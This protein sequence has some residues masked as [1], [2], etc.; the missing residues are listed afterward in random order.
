MGVRFSTTAWV[1]C[2]ACVQRRNE[3]T[4]AAIESLVADS[5]KG[6]N[7]THG[8]SSLTIAL[9]TLLRTVRQP[10]TAVRNNNN[11]NNPS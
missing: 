2:W 5:N 9:T 8:V 1:R 10:C 11:D 3:R 7:K 4:P 6:F